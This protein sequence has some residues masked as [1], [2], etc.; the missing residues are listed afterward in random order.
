MFPLQSDSWVFEDVPLFLE[1]DKI[2]EDLL[3]DSAALDLV[4]EHTAHDQGVKKRP[5]KASSAVGI[6]EN[7][8]ES[9]NQTKKSMHR[10]IERQRRQEMSGLYASVRSLLP[11]EYTKGRRSAADYVG[12]AVYYIKHMQTKMEEMKT[13][14]DK[15]KRLSSSSGPAALTDAEDRNSDTISFVQLRERERFRGRSG[16]LNQQ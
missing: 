4:N 9:S 1:Q 6:Q 12:Q 2:L 15:L 3:A 7:K 16:D 14:R 13:R 10:D 11:Q 5:R 8:D